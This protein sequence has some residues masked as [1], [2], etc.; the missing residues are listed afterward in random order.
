MS[1]T[2]ATV[3]VAFPGLPDGESQVRNFEPG[4]LVEGDLADVAIAE[5]WAVEGYDGDEEGE[6]EP[7]ERRPK[8]SRR[9]KGEEA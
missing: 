4:D 2:R 5:D 3:T 1:K 9:K 7:T 8:Q 6:T